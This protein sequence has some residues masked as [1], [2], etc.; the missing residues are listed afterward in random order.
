MRRQHPRLAVADNR[1]INLALALVAQ[2]AEFKM[3]E[4]EVDPGFNR[5]EQMA[6]GES[7]RPRE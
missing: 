6:G 3:P 1:K 7:L 5:F 4:V 2:V